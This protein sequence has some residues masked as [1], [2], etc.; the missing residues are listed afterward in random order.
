MDSSRRI[1]EIICY[2]G[3]GVTPKYVD[4]SSII[5]L[6]QK[7]IRNN[8]IDYKFA[9]FIDDNKN[10]NEAKF[11]KIGDILV[12]STGQ[13]TAGRVSFVKSLPADKRVI[14]DSHILVLRLDNYFEAKCLNYNLFFIEKTLQTFMDGSTGQG[15][16]DKL[17]LFNIKVNY[18]AD[19]PTQRKIASVLSALDDKIELNNKLNAEL[20]AMAKTLY[21]YWFVQFDFPNAEGKPYKASGGKMVYNEQLKREIPE[22]WEVN[23]LDALVNFTTGKLDSNAE[24]LRGEYLFFTC[25][26]LPSKTNTY[27]FDKDALLIAGNNANGNFHL[28]RYSGKF[29]AYQRTYVLSSECPAHLEVAYQLLKYELKSLKSKGNGSQTKFLTIGMLKNIYVSFTDTVIE[30]F[31]LRVVP[32]YKRQQNALKQNQELAS[33]RDWLLPMLMNGQVTVK[34]ACERVDAELRMVANGKEDCNKTI[35]ERII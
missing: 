35:N 25:A 4:D 34:D 3:K 13:G 28:N 14:V 17:R 22:G 18:P 12:N 21:D 32:I 8:K 2:Q 6:N 7:C 16:F 10:Y 26:S 9:Q 15:E 1:A 24:D 20:E 31:G 33:L 23:H 19:L 11:L 5:V 27:K 30:N 29:D